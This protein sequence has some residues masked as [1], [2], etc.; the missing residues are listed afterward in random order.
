MG[1]IMAQRP[2]YIQVK[3]RTSTDQDQAQTP[4]HVGSV[5]PQRR[6]SNQ[7]PLGS[8]TPPRKI[9]PKEPLETATVKPNTTGNGSN[10][11]QHLPIGVVG[12]ALSGVRPSSRPM[13]PMT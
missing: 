4:P 12:A 11:G 3:S 1:A 13:T 8:S 7:M 2:G 10:P 9:L 6:L 5:G